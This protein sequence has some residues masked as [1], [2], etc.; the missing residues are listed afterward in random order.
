MTRLKCPERIHCQFAMLHRDVTCRSCAFLRGGG[1][2]EKSP[3][4]ARRFF[5]A[6]CM[7]TGIGVRAKSRYRLLTQTVRVKSHPTS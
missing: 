5:S 2:R 1:G 3:T 6:A 7:F 4:Q